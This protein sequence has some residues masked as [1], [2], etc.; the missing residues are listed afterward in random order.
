[1]GTNVRNL[2]EGT[3]IEVSCQV[4]DGRLNTNGNWIR[5][6]LTNNQELTTGIQETT[7]G[8]I[9]VN[10]G[11]NMRSI[12]SINVTRIFNGEQLECGVFR[13]DQM[14]SNAQ[15]SIFTVNCKFWR[16]IYS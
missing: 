10:G 13:N 6:F 4:T 3:V 8:S 15:S 2:S 5:W 14:G 1:M 12:I 7:F 16:I 11:Q 9:T